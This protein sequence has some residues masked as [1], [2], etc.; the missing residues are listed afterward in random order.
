MTD[1]LLLKGVMLESDVHK[2][3][4]KIDFSEVK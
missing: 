1:E 4:Q 2:D 3:N